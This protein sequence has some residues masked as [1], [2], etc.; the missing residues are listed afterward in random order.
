MTIGNS[1]P[2]I[3]KPVNTLICEVILTLVFAF[4]MKFQF[5]NFGYRNFLP[6]AE[7]VGMKVYF[8]VA[9]RHIVLNRKFAN[10]NS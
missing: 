4:E 1:S 9:F 10:Y 3:G 7:S 8:G 6:N 5:L 2:M